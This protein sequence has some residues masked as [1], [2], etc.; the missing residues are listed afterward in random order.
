MKKK[1][2]MKNAYKIALGTPEEKRLCW[3]RNRRR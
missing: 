1:G 3:W 2:K